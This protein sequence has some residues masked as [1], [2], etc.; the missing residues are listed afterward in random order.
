MA[1]NTEVANLALHHIGITEKS[2]A[3]L[4]TENSVEARVCRR[5]YELAL[6]A[7]LRDY[8]WPFATKFESLNLIE[9][10]PNIEWQYAYSY[11]SDCM[12]IRR[13]VSGIK[14][15]SSE[16]R[17]PYKIANLDGQ[18]VI[19]TDQVEAAIEYVAKITD[20]NLMSSDFVSAFSL[21][22]G[23]YIAPS[24]TGGDPFKLGERCKREYIE[25]ISEAK[26]NAF[27][28]E[29]PELTDESSYTRARL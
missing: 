8:S 1:L 22:L 15:E 28:E 7:V 20:P 6:E 5:F 17:T 27:N 19:L 25:E 26:S 9:E 23:H 29:Q 12:K 24:L 16:E 2:I 14:D 13:M 18:K 3:N 4:E 10:N 11:P 21:R